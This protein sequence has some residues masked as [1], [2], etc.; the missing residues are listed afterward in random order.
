MIVHADLVDDLRLRSRRPDETGGEWDAV[1]DWTPRVRRRLA[2]A[3]YLGVRYG[4]APDQL[5]HALAARLVGDLD[6]D[7][8]M[9]VWRDAV[10]AAIAERRRVARRR[11]ERRLAERLGYATW[12]EYRQ[13]IYRD[14]HDHPTVH[15]HALAVGWR[16]R[17][18]TNER[19]E[20]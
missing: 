5:T 20:P 18:T 13:A 16:T 12:H 4:M 15:H 10:L 19:T 14:R 11:R 6:H 9:T 1:R 8:L 7:E 2:A 17:L 3:G